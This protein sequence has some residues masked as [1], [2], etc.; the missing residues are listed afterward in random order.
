MRDDPQSPLSRRAFVATTCTAATAAALVPLL[1]RRADA[2]PAN[3]S[4][5]RDPIS[6]SRD[7]AELEERSITEWQTALARGELTSRDLVERYLQRIESLDRSG[8]MS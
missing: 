7:V 1:P 8:P 6:P 2:A 3:S 5:S 4:A